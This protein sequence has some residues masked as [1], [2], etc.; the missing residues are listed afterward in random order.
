MLAVCLALILA[1]QAALAADEASRPAADRCPPDQRERPWIEDGFAEGM[2]RWRLEAQDPRTTLMSTTEI[3][4]RPALELATPA[5]ATLW[6]TTPLHGDHV[7]SLWATPLPAPASAGV[8]AGRVSDLNLLWNAT[9][10][11]G[12]LPRPRDG[13][14]AGLD[15]L[16]AWYVGFG[17]N[18]NTT[19]RLR[20]YDGSGRRVLIDG[21]ADPPEATP[22]DSRGAMTAA[23]R[24]VP[25]RPVHVQWLSRAPTEADPV[26]LR[27]WADGRLLFEQAGGA[28][29]LA[30]ALAL[31]TTASRWRFSQLSVTRCV[32]R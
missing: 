26:H 17:A 32:R 15:G 4:G 6:F 19:T 11:D 23:T 12:G 20:R 21:W 30:G 22:A 16:Q 28:P 14:L 9:E 18:G 24:L 13:S 25:G 10:P 8:H 27:W 3:N 29:L 31:R 5:G 7:V 2:A 1:G